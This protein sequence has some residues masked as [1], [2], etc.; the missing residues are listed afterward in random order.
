MTDPHGHV[1]DT[2]V[3]PR[4]GALPLTR[5]RVRG[6]LSATTDGG[7]AATVVEPAAARQ[8]ET[9]VSHLEGD[10]TKPYQH[11][12]VSEV[13]VAGGMSTKAGDTNERTFR[14]SEVTDDKPARR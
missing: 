2:G 13:T 7:A 14:V 5:G 8:T 12:Q 3:D 11:G 10:G 4:A 9:S 6:A 1:V